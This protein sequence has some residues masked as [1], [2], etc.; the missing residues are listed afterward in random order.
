MKVEDDGGERDPPD[1]VGA[2]IDHEQHPGVAG[3][4][5]VLLEPL[6][7]AGLGLEEVAQSTAGAEVVE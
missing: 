4:V 2:G 1:D 7:D 3:P 6:P 5:A